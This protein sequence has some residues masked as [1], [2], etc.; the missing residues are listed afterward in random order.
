MELI[1]SSHLSFKKEVFM[2]YKFICLV[3]ILS[4]LISAILTLNIIP[5]IVNVDFNEIEELKQ[6]S[7][8]KK[9]ILKIILIIVS[10]IPIASLIQA[11]KLN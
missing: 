8:N 1:I 4:L 3:Y 7:K 6:L 10:F 2:F 5:L 9:Q 11:I